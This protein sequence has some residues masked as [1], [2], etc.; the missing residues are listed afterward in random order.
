MVS[1]R[2][3]FLDRD[4]TLN[5]DPGYLND[6]LLLQLFQSVGPSLNRFTKAGFKNIVVSNQ[7]GI[8]RGLV[9]LENLNAIHAE[10]NRKLQ[11]FST[12]IDSF[13]ICPHLPKEQCLCRKPG[14][15]LFYEAAQEFSLELSS[16]YMIGDRP[17]D[18]LAG[19]RAGLAKVVLV[20]T[21]EGLMSRQ[22][23]KPG[24]ADFIAKDLQEAADW[25][26]SKAVAAN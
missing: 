25:I 19:R 6:P 21:G 26:L 23:L 8:S 15:Q 13:K 4:G 1:Q 2:A 24:D 22:E 9:S 14:T 7:S 20:L 5:D 12:Q 18:L 17:S 3:I 10:M 16:C 11:S